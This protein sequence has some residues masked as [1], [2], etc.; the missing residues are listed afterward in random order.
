MGTWQL[1][2]AKARLSEVIETA[3]KDGPQIIT[4]RGVKSA[5]ILPFDEWEKA[6]QP[7][8]KTLLEILQSGPQ[9][10]LQIPPRG[11]WKMRKPVKF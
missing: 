6:Q 8:A 2:Q 1:Q 3:K 4:Q 11:Q 10:D 9:F 7:K 5:V